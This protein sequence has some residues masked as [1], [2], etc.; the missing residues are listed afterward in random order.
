[1]QI[2]G[3]ALFLRAFFHWSLAKNFGSI[4]VKTTATTSWMAH[5]QE[6]RRLKKYTTRSLQILVKAETLLPDYVS[7][8]LVKG[9]ATKQAAQ[10]LHAKAALYA[11]RYPDALASAQSVILSNKYSLILPLRPVHG[12]QKRPR[13]EQEVCLMWNSTIPPTRSGNRRSIILC[14]PSVLL[15]IQQRRRRWYVCFSAF[16]NSFKTAT[17]AG[18]C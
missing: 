3:E 17:S 15:I 16:M 12:R 8:G 9:R 7:T 11:E 6:G 18:T 14:A 10:L 2:I 1:M 13:Q 4:V 5:S